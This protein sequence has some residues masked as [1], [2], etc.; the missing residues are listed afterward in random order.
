ME[1]IKKHNKNV[2]K[3]FQSRITCDEAVQVV[4]LVVFPEK[5]G[6]LSKIY[7]AEKGCTSA[8]VKPSVP[9]DL[10]ISVQETKKSC[11]CNHY[12]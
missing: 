2:K 10:P 5:I 4:Y 8:F 7:T 1:I 6:N 9:I 3:F 11:P 12:T